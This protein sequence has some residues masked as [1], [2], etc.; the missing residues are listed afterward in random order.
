MVPPPLQ[1][2]KGFCFPAPAAALGL[3]PAILLRASGAHRLPDAKQLPGFCTAPSALPDGPGIPFFNSAALPGGEVEGLAAAG[4]GGAGGGV[5][6]Q[7]PAGI[8][9]GGEE[10]RHRV[11]SAVVD[12]AVA[13]HQPRPWAAE[14]PGMPPY[15]AQLGGEAL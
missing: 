12:A 10:D 13:D 15:L 9:Q 1:G 6:L 3:P 2:G 14:G 11:G 8:L 5:R 7:L 4:G